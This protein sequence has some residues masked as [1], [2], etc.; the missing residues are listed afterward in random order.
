MIDLLKWY[1]LIEIL[2]LAA[3]PLAF[4]C[5]H[6][7]ADRGWAYAKTIGLLVPLYV[8]WLLAHCWIPYRFSLLFFGVLVLLCISLPIA[9]RERRMIGWWFSRQWRTVLILELVFLLAFAYF[10]A[11]R[12]YNPEIESR[13]LGRFGSEKLMDIMFVN[14]VH[15]S[16]TFPPQDAWFSGEK[17][18]YY[19]YGYY[20][21]SAMCKLSGVPTQV[22]YN[23]ALVTAFALA[24]LSAFALGWHLTGRWW[25]AACGAI[26]LTLLG[27][28]QGFRLLVGWG[29]PALTGDRYLW[30]CSRVINPPGHTINEFPYFSFLWGDLHG[31]VTSLPF[32]VFVLACVAS[33]WTTCEKN[34]GRTLLSGILI[35]LGYGTA[36]ACNN[37]DLPAYGG[38]IC[39]SALIYF[40]IQRSAH[41]IVGW[42][43]AAVSQR[44]VP[45]ALGYVLFL[46]F[47]MD[48]DAPQ[49]S[50][51]CEIT[52]KTPIDE[53][54]SMFGYFAFVIGSWIL[55]LLYRSLKRDKNCMRILVFSVAILSI[56]LG[57]LISYK[58]TVRF[59][60]PESFQ[61]EYMFLTTG[62][63]LA[64]LF[65]LA[66]ELVRLLF[67]GSF[68]GQQADSPLAQVSDIPEPLEKI[69]FVAIVAFLAVSILLGTEYVAISDFYGKANERMNTLFKFHYQAWTM[70]AIVTAYAIAAI[71]TIRSR[72]KWLWCVPWIVVTGFCLTFTVKGTQIKTDRSDPWLEGRPAPTLDG[73][74]WMRVNRPEDLQMIQWL[75]DEGEAQNPGRST[76]YILEAISGDAYSYFGRI[77]AFTGFPAVIG[78]P[79]HEGIWRSHNPQVQQRM[80]E[81]RAIY[82]SADLG[83]SCRLTGKYF[84]D[85]IV[86][87]EL[88]KEEYT[89]RLLKAKFPAYA[90]EAFAAGNSTIYAGWEQS[91]EELKGV[92][93]ESV[94]DRTDKVPPAQKRRLPVTLTLDGGEEKLS[95]PRGVAI[96]P[97]GRIYVIDSKNERIQVFAR[98][99]SHVMNIPKPAETDPRA[100]LGGEFC[101]PSDIAVSTAGEVF[102]ADT[103]GSAGEGYGRVVKYDAGGN[104]VADWGSPHGFYGPRGIALSDEGEVFVTDTGN[105]RIQV[106]DSKGKFLRMWGETGTG[107]GQF[108]EPVGIAVSGNRVYT[109]DTGNRRVQ[110]FDSRGV[111][112]FQ[113]V[114]YGWKGNK[115]SIEPY[116]SVDSRNRIWLSDSTSGRIQ[117]FSP[118]GDPILW[119]YGDLSRPTG[120]D[121]RAG[122]G[123]VAE[124]ATGGVLVFSLE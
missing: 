43:A 4:I 1:V 124:T 11:V 87:G 32:T 67:P 107:K 123:V 74:A 22:G 63:L 96:G 2:S 45:A 77:S 7:C 109:C 39:V 41:S 100:K 104:F 84:V 75:L 113:F 47:F 37:W 60:P 76:P 20:V 94:E 119:Y 80:R 40:P 97:E 50:L 120:L 33:L 6:R 24:T 73:R 52:S 56:P 44:V 69:R 8:A 114:P 26:A 27:N 38:L 105:K 95:E 90:E 110:V 53:F 51:N 64:A 91:C 58:H 49:K 42:I 29:I 101:C 99:G 122:V 79:N 14:S 65:I 48:F 70:M 102:V 78:W 111:W 46:P 36:I 66:R 28:P 82:Q 106:F 92:K 118:G 25:A 115:V 15:Q 86:V 93:L 112:Q 83:Q 121:I 10:A 55:W 103:W 5:F 59:A 34:W 62:L 18:N 81:G 23:L 16:V 54:L 61:P 116:L 9:W 98:D 21:C 13:F 17:I 35:A 85:Y 19:W 108:D 57:L 68:E 72:L 117:V 3:A 31:H 89:V 12:S 88:E 71:L 30:D